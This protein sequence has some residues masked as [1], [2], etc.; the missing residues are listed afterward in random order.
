MKIRHN[1]SRNMLFVVLHIILLT[2]FVS[3]CNQSSDEKLPELSPSATVF[4]PSNTPSP[5]DKPTE[6]PTPIPSATHTQTN[7]FTPSY[8]PTQ[9]CLNMLS[10][11]NGAQFSES[12]HVRFEWEPTIGAVI[13]RLE[14]TLPDGK[15]E[16]SET[17]MTIADRYLHMYPT[18]GTYTWKV[19]A[20]NNLKGIL[21]IAGPFNF[22]K[23]AW[24]ITPVFENDAKS[25]KPSKLGYTG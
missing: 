11:Q 14:I 17:F 7:T 9:V 22:N 19:V 10:P 23:V 20:L 24:I 25:R 16:S 4:I 2:S 13:Y 8:T 15:T 18:G 12:G 1:P 3:A 5:T 6:T 21:C